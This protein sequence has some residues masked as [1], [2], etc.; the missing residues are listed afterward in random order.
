MPGAIGNQNAVGNKGGGRKSAY[1]ENADATLLREMFLNPMSRDE[2]Q[3]KLKSGKYSLK[4]L[5]VSKGYSGNERVLLA[6]FHKYFPDDLLT[7]EQRQANP[8][9][10]DL[11]LNTV[12]SVDDVMALIESTIQGVQSGTISVQAAMNVSRLASLALKGIEVGE[13]DKKMD[14]VNSVINDRKLKT[15]K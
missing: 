15:K 9:G 2:I 8:D 6:L 14:L 4:D 7:M 11:P 5:F 3:A 10:S 12:K 13:L 1:Q